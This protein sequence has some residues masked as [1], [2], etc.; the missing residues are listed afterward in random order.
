MNFF[1][2]DWNYI[3]LDTNIIIYIDIFVPNKKEI[4]ITKKLCKNHEYYQ[5]SVGTDL[6][7]GNGNCKIYGKTLFFDRQKVINLLN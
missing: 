1:E 7:Q 6:K 3:N 2:I 4:K 5:I